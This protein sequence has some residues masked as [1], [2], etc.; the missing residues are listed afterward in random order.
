MSSIS[1]KHQT[2]SPRVSRF[3]SVESRFWD[4]S[5]ARLWADLS[6]GRQV[7][8]RWDSTYSYVGLSLHSSED[9]APGV[10]VVEVPGLASFELEGLKDEVLRRL[11]LLV[12]DARGS[13]FFHGRES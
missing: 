11:G 12:A 7:C 9:D 5:A 1:L 8:V 10:E 13:D 3:V 4:E 2:V 6:D